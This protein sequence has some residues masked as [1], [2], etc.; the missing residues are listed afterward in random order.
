[1][2]GDDS[3]GD[4]EAALSIAQKRLLLAFSIASVVACIYE[5]A[6][7]IRYYGVS[8]V[9]FSGAYYDFAEEGRTGFD[10]ALLFLMQFGMASYLIAK[11]YDERY[12]RLAT[13]VLVLGF[14][15]TA[16]YHIIQGSRFSIVVSLIVFIGANHKKKEA[17]VSV[18]ERIASARV[19]KVLMAIVLA[20][21]VVFTTAQVT[22]GRMGGKSASQHYEFVY[23]DSPV[24]EG[25]RDLANYDTN[26]SNAFFSICDYIGEAPFVFTYY[27]R[28]FTPDD[29]YMGANTFRSLGQ[30]FR[31]LGIKIMPS[32]TEIYQELG[33]GSGKY[34]GFG[35]AMIQDFGIILTP[36]FT[37]LGGYLLSRIEVRRENSVL[38]KT[39]YPCCL[40]ICIFAPI[41]Y[42]YVGRMDFVIL[43]SLA[44][45]ALLKILKPATERTAA[46]MPAIGHNE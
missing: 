20:G 36:L 41:Y 24:K 28:Y 31:N 9:A 14:W 39:L 3:P 43:A 1:M 44:M 18:L 46:T 37:I 23:G 42:Y 26:I 10:K 25:F 2:S 11:A 12:G 17:K 5:I 35:Y 29:P 33:G 22:S 4:G 38:C 13:V 45:F 7:F 34:S 27:W 40:A 19:L 15:A 8:Y 16:A 32:Q 6:S 30:I 21:G